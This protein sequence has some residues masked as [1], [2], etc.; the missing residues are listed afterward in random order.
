[1]KIKI[2]FQIVSLLFVVKLNAQFNKQWL[3]S[4]GGQVSIY[5]QSLDYKSPG[6]GGYKVKGNQSTIGLTFEGGYVLFK[7]FLASYNLTY[8]LWEYNLNPQA[9]FKV[10][11]LRN[12]INFVKLFPIEQNFYF[13]IGVNPF[14]EK[15]LSKQNLSKDIESKN[16]G[17]VFLAGFS[18]GIEKN[19]LLSFS[20][21]RT[22]DAYP[23]YSGLKS[24]IQI[25]YK[26]MFNNGK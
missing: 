16:S 13:N 7:N 4:G 26:Y 9:K 12:G 24:G 25:N 14:I 5:N 11:S 8:Q 22:L 3:L 18:I 15:I 21:Y 23:S 10:T 6:V 1:M 17:C 20:L 2:L 19:S